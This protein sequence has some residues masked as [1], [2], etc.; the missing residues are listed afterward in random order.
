MAGT[1]PADTSGSHYYAARATDANLLR[2]TAHGTHGDNAEF[3]KFLFYRGVGDFTAPLTV[4]QSADGDSFTL[5]NTG[6]E[7]LGNLF[8]Y[9]V[10]GD[11]A[12]HLYVESLA[13]GAS[14]TV[15]LRAAQNLAPLSDARADIARRMREALVREG[16]YEREAAAMV[17]AWDDSWFA[18]QG[19]RVLYTLPRAWTDRIL[20]LTIDPKPREIVRVMVG[21]AEAITPT[22]EWEVLKQVVR[23]S[24]ADAATRARAID[25]TRKLGYGRFMEPIT[26]RLAAK[27]PGREFST[28]SREL[29]RAASKPAPKSL[30]AK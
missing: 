1:L 29:L 30:A 3:E 13:P 5:Q 25:D 8:L 7:P 19:T 14:N 9:A 11:G 23:Y 24:D 20:P 4:T 27:V 12:K 21:R 2:V 6:K 28:L 18:E 26:R 10:R 16:L 22:M 15:N 17:E